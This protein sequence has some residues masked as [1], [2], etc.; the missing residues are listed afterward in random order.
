LLGLGA[1]PMPLVGND[2][3]PETFNGAIAHIE[4]GEPVVHRM[5]ERGGC[6]CSY[7]EGLDVIAPWRFE[8]GKF[9]CIP[10]GIA[11]SDGPLPRFA[12]PVAFGQWFKKTCTNQERRGASISKQSFA[13]FCSYHDA[14]IESQQLE[15]KSYSLHGT[16]IVFEMEITGFVVAGSHRTDS[17]WVPLLEI[18]IRGLP[19]GDYQIEVIWRDK[20]VSYPTVSQKMNLHV[21]RPGG[22]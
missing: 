21:H 14:L 22:I 13:V 4:I 6:V 1:P 11:V 17:P 16:K 8:K 20:S 10:F 19:D 18:P 2:D 15:V 9:V 7:K 3:R 12:S 5:E